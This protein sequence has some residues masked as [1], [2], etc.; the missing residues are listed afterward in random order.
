VDSWNIGITI[1]SQCLGKFGIR[2]EDRENLH[3]HL[4]NISQDLK[5]KSPE[6]WYSMNRSYLVPHGGNTLLEPYGGNIGILLETIYPEM[7]WQ[8]WRFKVPPRSVWEDLKM[9]KRAFQWLER[10]LRVQD[11]LDWYGVASHHVNRTLEGRRLIKRYGNLWNMIRSHYPLE[12]WDVG[13]W[14]NLSISKSQ[15]LLYRTVRKL[16]PKEVRI[17]YNARL[18][19]LRYGDTNR[20][21]ELDIWIPD[22]NLAIEYQGMQ[23]YK[24]K[25]SIYIC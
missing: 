19:S 8:H 4:A 9:R 16:I 25:I 20:T 14:K 18:P 11:P 10:I 21:M 3:A 5:L 7:E 22:I 13:Y 6:D 12:N 2:W 23:H 17:E 24:G 1:I 15:D